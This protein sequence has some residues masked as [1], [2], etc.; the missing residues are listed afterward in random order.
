MP[1]Y[2]RWKTRSSDDDQYDPAL[3]DPPSREQQ[4]AD[5]LDE[6]SQIGRVPHGG[7]TEA[8]PNRPYCKLDQSCCDFCCGN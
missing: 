1:G 6:Q 5:Y 7:P 4:E 8:N 3:D 2:D